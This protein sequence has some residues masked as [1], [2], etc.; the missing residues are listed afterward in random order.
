[1]TQ[2]LSPGKLVIASHNTGKI[3]EI[4]ELLT[5]FGMDVGSAFALGLEDVEETGST[6]AENATL[7]ARAAA[8]ATGLP[9]LSD[10]SGLCVNAL[11]GAPGIYSA[12]WAEKKDGTRDFEFAMKK[13]EKAV[14]EQLADADGRND[15][16]AYFICVLCLSMPGGADYLF[17]GRVYGSLVFPGRGGH[18]FGYD[19]IFL[20]D[21]EKVT[22]GEM[23]PAQ[24]HAMSHRAKAFSQLVETCFQQ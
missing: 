8:S 6:F 4:G 10:D 5:P 3:R 14:G 23:D 24:K 9:A 22:F 11:E 16:S 12:R 2:I 15:N 18:G 20:A 7:K 1:V 17:E 19:P 13:L 21:G